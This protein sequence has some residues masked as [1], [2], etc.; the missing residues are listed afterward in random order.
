MEYYSVDEVEKL[1]SQEDASLS[2]RFLRFVTSS[3]ICRIFLR[4]I[5]GATSVVHQSRLII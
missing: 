1:Q 5:N 4:K 3:D 2:F